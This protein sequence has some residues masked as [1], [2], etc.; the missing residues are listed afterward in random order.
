[1]S[2]VTMVIVLVEMVALILVQLSQVGLVL[3]S[4][5]AS[6]LRNLHIVVN[7]LVPDLDM[8]IMVRQTTDRSI[9]WLR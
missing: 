1:M 8:A 9:K 2:N 6:P 7:A 4:S 3:A 5:S